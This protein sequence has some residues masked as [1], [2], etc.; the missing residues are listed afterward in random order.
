MRDT[1]LL[2]CG[3]G[4][5]V[6]WLSHLLDD[7]SSILYCLR[8][9]VGEHYS[10]APMLCCRRCQF[11]H[12]SLYWPFLFSWKSWICHVCYCYRRIWIDVYRC[13]LG[14]LS[15]R[16]QFPFARRKVKRACAWSCPLRDSIYFE[17]H[18]FY[19]RQC[20]HDV[21]DLVE[22]SLMIAISSMSWIYHSVFPDI[23]C[24]AVANSS[25][26]S[27]SA[28]KVVDPAHW[29]REPRQTIHS[30]AYCLNG[31]RR[32]KSSTSGSSHFYYRYSLFSS[33]C[34][35]YRFTCWDIESPNGS[36]SAN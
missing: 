1:G 24:F 2:F 8:M 12:L 18:R 19:L 22:R 27:K 17:R 23:N 14:M 36:N 34:G 28:P 21:F 16:T 11:T 7:L 13:H 29:N 25:Q 5:P 20:L 32:S 26:S 9:P 31:H 15:R 4:R 35:A 30:P 3:S 33:S 6:L 10:P